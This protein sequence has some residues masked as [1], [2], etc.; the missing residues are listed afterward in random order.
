ML[1]YIPYICFFLFASCHHYFIKW[2]LI[3]S[4]ASSDGKES[5]CH[6]GDPGLIP[7]SGRSPGEGYDNPLQYCCLGNS[8]G[9][10]AWRATFHRV[11]K[12]QTQLRP[13]HFYF[14]HYK[15]FRGVPSWLFP[16]TKGNF[17]SDQSLSRVRL[18]ATP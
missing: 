10:G 3:L 7:G 17:S 1:R 2:L 6:V 8:M 18:F 9:R 16:P 5:T 13:Y 4:P 15:S 11:T 14:L 12:S